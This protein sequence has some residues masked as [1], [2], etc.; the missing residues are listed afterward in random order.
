MKLL[1]RFSIICLLLLGFSQSSLAASVTDFETALDYLAN[2][3]TGTATAINNHLA[4]STA[5]AA[6]GTIQRPAAVKTF[7]G[8]ELGLSGGLVVAG[9]LEKITEITTYAISP[10]FLAVPEL[11]FSLTGMIHG[12][13]GLLKIPA[14]GKVDL[15][16]GHS[17]VSANIS[18]TFNGRFAQWQVEARIQPDL[19]VPFDLSIALGVGN[20][21]GNYRIANS[22]TEEIA[23]IQ[24]NGAEY[25]QTLDTTVFMSSDWDVTA[26]YAKLVVSKSLIV[27]HPYLG[28]GLQ[29]S[30]GEVNTVVGASGTLNLDPVL[31]GSDYQDTLSVRG[32]ASAEPSNFDFRLL[33]GFQINI[34][35][36]A[37]LNLSGEYGHNVYGATLGVI[38][39]FL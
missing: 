37:A 16:F 23:S 14:L 27:I 12:K 13:V 20:M 24:Y 39:G 5:F 18:D 19:M 32:P 2:D 3:F 30:T 8:F 17:S 9:N 35:P 31:P 25:A 4:K 10:D 22:H 28:V 6:G 26:Y 21:K 7:P 11:F 38:V 1:S 29:V 15:G 33:G 36:I 34:L